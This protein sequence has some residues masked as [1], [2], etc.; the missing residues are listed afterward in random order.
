MLPFSATHRR[1]APPQAPLLREVAPRERAA[2]LSSIRLPPRAW[3]AKSPP[4]T[5]SLHR[6]QHWGPRGRALRW[7]LPPPRLPMA[8][9]SALLASC[10]P[11][12]I[13]MS[14]AKQVTGWPSTLNEAG[15]SGWPSPKKEHDMSCLWRLG[16]KHIQCPGG[17]TCRAGPT[18]IGPCLARAR[19]VLSRAGPMDIYTGKTTVGC[20]YHL[21]ASTE[22]ALE[23][24][25]WLKMFNTKL[26]KSST[27]VHAMFTILK[28]SLSGVGFQWDMK[29]VQIC[30]KRLL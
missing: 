12:P 24:L 19:V 16:T 3:P 26:G 8:H 25:C 23:S 20:R 21:T 1:G 30:S 10:L 5:C 6:I 7:P 29:I 18:S 9:Q 2:C 28:S 4:P 14:L 11:F 15:Y 13:S 17:M 22:R 27:Q